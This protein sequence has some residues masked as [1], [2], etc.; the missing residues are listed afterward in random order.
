MKQ[1]PNDLFFAWVESEIAEGRSVKF[2]LKGNSMFPL[3][4]NGKDE[5]ILEKCFPE[6]LK[7]MDVIL[8]R[9][10]GAHVLHRIIKRKG[11]DLLI[12]GDGSIV[13]MEHCTINDVVGKVTSICRSSGKTILIDSWKWKL[14]SHLWRRMGCSRKWI[15]KVAYKL[16]LKQE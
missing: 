13:A 6:N 3:L 2:R 16:F 8:F 4:R 9:Y 14:Y 7:P 12:Q 15:L 1:I 5:V 11:N 10:R